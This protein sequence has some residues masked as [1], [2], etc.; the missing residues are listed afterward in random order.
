MEP[1]TSETYQW[2]WLHD[3]RWYQGV[4]A[5]FGQEV[6]NEINAEAIRFVA[7][8]VA[9]HVARTCGRPVDELDFDEIVTLFETCPRSMWP[10]EFVR[11]D[12]E[13]TGENEFVV[14]IT[15]NF[16]LDMLRSA[17]ALDGYSCP[18]LQMREGWFEGLGLTATENRIES[19][20]KDGAPTCRYFAR[21]ER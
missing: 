7:R 19:C 3:A 18:C 4:A 20:Q 13:V 15:K 9:K 8:R 21:I 11:F 6:A 17:G 16:A 10:E 14:D 1:T 5:R 2:W 12:R